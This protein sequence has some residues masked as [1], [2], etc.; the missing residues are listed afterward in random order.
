MLS[1]QKTWKMRAGLHEFRVEDIYF[2]LLLAQSGLPG[3]YN[4]VGGSFR[5]LG[6]LFR[7]HWR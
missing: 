2:G 4:L 6:C 3:Q 1:I 7:N 5:I